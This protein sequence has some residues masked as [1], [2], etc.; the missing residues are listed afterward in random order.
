[1]V[2]EEKL[3]GTHEIERDDFSNYRQVYPGRRG[4][5]NTWK[6]RL[7]QYTRL[8]P[9]YPA[10]VQGERRLTWDQFNR[11]CNRLAHGLL[12]AGVRK[13]D[14]VAILGFDSIEWM[15]VYFAAS[16]IGA[17]PVNVNPR[18]V[19]DEIAYILE[20]SDAV[21]V[22]VEEG[23]EEGV[24]GIRGRLPAL[25]HV[26]VYGVGRPPAHLPEGAVAY[27]DFKAALEGNPRIRVYD[28]DFCFLMYTGGTTGYPKGTVWDGEQRVRGL[29]MAMICGLMP[30]VD[31][32]SEFP[33]EALAGFMGIF[34]ASEAG[35]KKAAAFLARP[36]VR[37]ALSS[38]RSKR[39]SFFL[40]KSMVGN[41]AVLKLVSML[42]GG[43]E[44][45]RI[46]P[47]S[48]LF[49][50]AGYEGV[51]S[52]LGGVAA[53]TILLPHPHPFDA[54]EFWETVER[55][56]VH[57]VVIVGDA[58][59]LPILE[60]LKKSEEE[61]RVY[62]LGNLMGIIS[63]GVRWSPH[64]KRELLQRLPGML[65]LDEM[66]ASETS[67][68]FGELTTSRD[69]EM[70]QAGARLAG[71]PGGLSA[72]RLFP[73]RVVDAETGE[74]VEPG[75]SQVGEFV[76]GGWMALGYWKCPS[77]TARDFRVIDGRRWFFVGD[78][79]M[80]D[81]DGKFHLLGR[82]GDYLINSGGEK[83]Y[84]EEVEGI[85]KAHPAVADAAV[86]GIPD[87]RW[88]QAVVALVELSPGEEAGEA[89]LEEFCR[90]RMAGYKRPRHIVFVDQ[91]PRSAVGKINRATAMALVSEKLEGVNPGHGTFSANASP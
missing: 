12:K 73:C 2:V 87:P 76:Y 9:D 11:G 22:F 31:R 19:P 30:I 54:R 15:E 33:E 59:A 7:E 29:D 63:S 40:L 17:V 34:V 13:E 85:I 8:L 67:A 6:Y 3:L 89:E 57:N 41:A 18:F 23:Y 78:E 39:V 72:Q 61:G 58:F 64:I 75:S 79:G 60:E 44:G 32:L 62:R 49:H 50:G 65:V 25:R 16:K 68:T 47:A 69:S 43:R 26:V 45:V 24:A 80:I 38:P 4:R 51:F 82:G 52:H 46:L 27:D 74:D 36:G 20:D 35:R 28:D 48:P 21:A 56:R 77:K 37:A 1:V 71:K 42:K 66:G 55:E 90:G 86:V 14:R 53:A 81:A 88:G 91:V 70:A 5:K 84:S 10:V 83:V